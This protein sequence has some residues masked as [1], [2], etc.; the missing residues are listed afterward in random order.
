MRGVPEQS[1]FSY[2][3]LSSN[4]IFTNM[5]LSEGVSNMDSIVSNLREELGKIRTGRATPEIVESVTV[6]VYESQMPISH[7]A[8]ISVPDARTIVVQPWDEGNV[9]A[10]EKALTKSDLGMPPVVDGKII[11]LSMP[12]L[13]GEL[14]EE[15]IK[16]MKEKVEAAR[17]AVRGVRHKI[18]AA[19]DE[20]ASAGG[21]SEDDVKRRKD[22][23][24][25]E[26]KKYMDSIEDIAEQKESE[27]RT[28]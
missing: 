21:V 23:I 3:P 9:K 8:T 1:C 27:L 4:H 16:D 7:V 12:A 2:G 11:R 5:E 19:V 22:E 18:M 14:R 25:K 15:F 20:E 28:I 10:I 6:E 26:V 24:E 13:T 17:V